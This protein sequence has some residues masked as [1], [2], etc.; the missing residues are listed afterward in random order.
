MISVYTTL[1]IK[2]ESPYQFETEGN[3]NR[4]RVSLYFYYF[5]QENDY[6][7]WKPFER[8]INSHTNGDWVIRSNDKEYKKGKRAP[9]GK[10]RLQNKPHLE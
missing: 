6:V 1:R 8:Y 2:Y 9:F 10:L 3:L 5:N 4:N 7:V